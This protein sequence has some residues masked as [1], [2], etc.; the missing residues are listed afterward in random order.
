MIDFFLRHRR[1]AF[2]ILLILL[3]ALL[4]FSGFF[5]FFSFPAFPVKI[6]GVAGDFTDWIISVPSQFF[7]SG[8]ASTE[9]DSLRIEASKLKIAELECLNIRKENDRLKELLDIP[10]EEELKPMGAKVL[11]G[12]ISSFSR[13]IFVNRGTADG[14]E[15]G[16]P[17]LFEDKVAGKI[18]KAGRHVSLVYLVNHPEISVDVIVART[19]TRGVFTGG[20]VC[21][22]KYVDSEQE[23]VPGD[24]LYSSGRGGVFPQRFRVGIVDSVASQK[25]GVFQKVTATPVIDPR[26]LDFVFIVK[27]PGLSEIKDM[28]QE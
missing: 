28:A 17:V 2:F 21:K 7:V 19:G 11:M 18:I 26:K 1:L 13:S 5:S 12:G 4:R 8:Q 16:S 23:I 27:S 9:N 6:A 15:A 3:T 24:E 10:L 25:T 14:V 20:T 22:V